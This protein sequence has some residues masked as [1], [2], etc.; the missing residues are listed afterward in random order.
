MHVNGDWSPFS[1]L[2]EKVEK[3]ALATVVSKWGNADL[4][5]EAAISPLRNRKMT[6]LF[7]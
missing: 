2:G 5:E 6:F 1:L 3:Q 4:T 7:E